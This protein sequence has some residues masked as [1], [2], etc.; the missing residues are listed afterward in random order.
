[1]ET[2]CFK[3]SCKLIVSPIVIQISPRPA[4]YHFIYFGDVQY[5]ES[6]TQEYF[7]KTIHLSF[8]I[9]KIISGKLERREHYA[10]DWITY[11]DTTKNNFCPADK[12]MLEKHK[13]KLLVACKQSQENK[14][15]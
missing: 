7:D 4:P 3:L 2:Q 1:M 15:E 11:D 5:L 14:L 12:Q 6:V 13:I 9:A 8:Y 10:L